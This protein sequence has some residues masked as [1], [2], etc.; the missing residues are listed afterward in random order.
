MG[1]WLQSINHWLRGALLSLGMIAIAGG[2]IAV[3]SLPA[4]ALPRI[5]AEQRLFLP[6]SLEFLGAYELP[7][8]EFEQTRV[9]G[10]SALAYDR[11][12]DRFYALSDDRSEFAP[13]RFYTL[14]LQLNQRDSERPEIQ[15]I[16]IESVT[17]LKDETGQT[18]ARGTV[19][20][21]GMALSPVRSLWISSEGVTRANIPAFIKEFDLQTG[22]ALR[23]LPIPEHYQPLRE[24][25][26]QV[27]GIR[28]NLGFEALTINPGSYGTIGLEPFRLF[29]AT[30]AALAQDLDATAGETRN[31][32]LHYMIDAGQITSPLRRTPS[33]LVVSEHLYPL[34]PPPAQT[35]AHGLTALLA[36]DQGG[37]FLGLERSFGVDGFTVRLFQ[38]ATGGASDIRD[39][40]SLQGELRGVAPIRK[41]LLLDL[42]T[43][44]IRLDNLEGMTLGPQL[45]DGSPS[46]VLVSDDNFRSE[47]VTQFLLFR[48]KGL[49]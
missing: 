44:G 32:L 30:E 35:I 20:P 23:D 31:R 34:A 28:D 22:Q 5:T 27:R 16:A 1:N 26:Q 10:L 49:K 9:G 19:D 37:H 39:R 13:A 48:L 41:Q 38:L 33:T 15:Q 45:P 14:Q 17:L 40:P 4:L 29:V 42:A 25:S 18:F 43:L 47:Q 7:T 46:L 24:E 21:E 6:L 3:C 11:Q 12:R 2:L 8:Q 36:L